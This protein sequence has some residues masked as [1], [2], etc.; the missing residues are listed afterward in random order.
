MA[1]V[2]G[3]PLGDGTPMVVS[4]NR[5]YD[6]DPYIR[7]LYKQDA[8][9]ESILPWEF[10]Q[11][12]TQADEQNFLRDWFGDR[13]I[14]VQGGEPEGYM[15]LKQVWMCS[16]LY[17]INNRVPAIV[18][19]WFTQKDNQELLEDAGMREHMCKIAE[20]SAFFP[21]DEPRGCGEKILRIVT[22]FI[23]Q[24]IQQSGPHDEPEKQGIAASETRSEVSTPEAAVHTNPTSAATLPP[25][26]PTKPAV[27]QPEEGQKVSPLADQTTLDVQK[28]TSNS[29]RR[30]ELQRTTSQPVVAGNH[31][32]KVVD[33]VQSPQPQPARRPR[34][35]SNGGRGSMRS[36]QR[37]TFD[38]NQHLQSPPGYAVYPSPNN[39]ASY[40]IYNQMPASSGAAMPFA[41]P[42]AQMPPFQSMSPE[43]FPMGLPQQYPAHGPQFPMHQQGPHQQGPH[44]QGPHQQGPHQQGPHQQGPHQQ[45]PHQQ[46]PHQQVMGSQPI[47]IANSQMQNPYY[48]GQFPLND[49][50]NEQYDNT[51]FG[52]ASPYHL[53]NETYNKRGGGHRKD[54]NG[55]RGGR[56]RGYP[57]SGG[58]GKSSRGKHDFASDGR[59]AFV[60]SGQQHVARQASTDYGTQF[61]MGFDR[62]DRR[63]SMTSNWRSKDEQA[64]PR[65][66]ESFPA[67]RNFS[68]PSDAYNRQMR[69]YAPPGFAQNTQ[70]PFR[71]M[72]V[73]MP[74]APH[75]GFSPIHDELSEL[76][77]LRPENV[78]TRFSVGLG[79]THVNKLLVFD[80]YKCVPESVLYDYFTRYSKTLR[81]RMQGSREPNAPLSGMYW[82]NFAN[83][84]EARNALEFSVHSLPGGDVRLEVP[85]QFWDPW[86]RSYPGFDVH[87]PASGPAKP[88]QLQKEGAGSIQGPNTPPRDSR[89]ADSTPTVE[90]SAVNVAQ[91][92]F[93]SGD[94]TP[95]PSTM[96][97]SKNDGGPAVIKRKAKSKSKD[98][99][100]PDQNVEPTQ[101]ANT[102]PEG[103][104]RKLREVD[105][106]EESA[107]LGA[108]SEDG[109]SA[110]AN[111]TPAK[112]DGPKK[113]LSF[114]T[115]GEVVASREDAQI[116]SEPAFTSEVFVK[117]ELPLIQHVEHKSSAMEVSQ[118]TAYPEQGSDKT[119]SSDAAP[120][121]ELKNRDTPDDAVSPGS[122]T[123]PSHQKPDEKEVDEGFNAATG[124][125]QIQKGSVSTPP[126]SKGS[127]VASKP[128]SASITAHRNEEHSEMQQHSAAQLAEFKAR[129]DSKVDEQLKVTPALPTSH[130]KKAAV[131]LQA[132]AVKIEEPDQK[133]SDNTHRQPS[134]TRRSVSGLSVPPTPAF[135]TAPSRPALVPDTSSVD[136]RA[137]SEQAEAP[138]TTEQPT[139]SPEAG[140]QPKHTDKSKGP[141][142][143]ES[144]NP[145]G[146]S[147]QKK[148]PKV[149]KKGTLRGKPKTGDFAE[150]DMS[151]A[152]SGTSTPQ[153]ALVTSVAA[154]GTADVVPEDIATE[155]QT[156]AAAP[157][158]DV[159]EKTRHA[160]TPE[161]DATE[162]TEKESKDRVSASTTQS[163]SPSKASSTISSFVRGIFGSNQPHASSPTEIVGNQIPSEAALTETKAK[164]EG[165]DISESV[166]SQASGQLGKSVA[167]A[168]PPVHH[169]QPP[170][171][172][173]PAS[174]DL[175]GLRDSGDSGGGDLAR[176]FDVGLGI[177]ASDE[178]AVTEETAKT[179]KKRPKKKKK[180]KTGGEG[181]DGATGDAADSKSTTAAAD[182]KVAEGSSSRFTSEYRA[183]NAP[184]ISDKISETSSHTLAGE[185]TSNP[186]TPSSSHDQSPS[187]RMIDALKQKKANDNLV[188]AKPLMRKTHRRVLT[189]KSSTEVVEESDDGEETN[190]DASGD[191]S[192]E[193]G[194]NK[195][196]PPVL[197]LYVGPGKVA[198]SQG[199]AGTFEQKMPELIDNAEK[200][201]EARRG[202]NVKP[203]AK[204]SK[205]EHIY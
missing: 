19:W 55:S 177:S 87:H 179:K 51:A 194:S 174:H 178:A 68:G 4:S 122:I 62:T 75:P 13:E 157:I 176:D 170:F 72:E 82:L 173:F 151:R 10:P 137:V 35:F 161:M 11:S 197:Y 73:Y 78:L 86:H 34:G 57:S 166:H 131:P 59:D 188:Q 39:P 77:K 16:A 1:V 118:T 144:L 119:A 164:G 30:N 140:S 199:F 80:E 156:H 109:G 115:Q 125:P 169:V 48:N 141:S 99:Q 155:S 71:I 133:P 36:N 98:K 182:P 190:D 143:T 127:R 22:D 117:T 191:E 158:V 104:E 45:G 70:M 17:N 53:S 149:A 121:A 136:D 200:E 93:L 29:S 165:S 42:S 198:D 47:Y 54:S 7:R 31:L 37:P 145:F 97:T 116:K 163:S 185:E 14:H 15:F 196:K 132:P 101:P 40:Q 65:Q 2:D 81:V 175:G 129:H 123:G 187:K 74:P 6:L 3:L 201:R 130:M 84:I 108:Q 183:V 154:A 63:A 100:L 8:R 195:K 124:S 126:V 67:G 186:P 52:N 83:N 142:Q 28:S 113:T 114:E 64:Q 26:T 205:G 189:P 152:V 18:D 111:G 134:D 167:A 85:K 24:R 147:T 32:P 107:M 43:N 38:R 76:A 66:H 204:T 90:N 146:K 171:Q 138:S 168:A 148:K 203:S 21:A 49:R 96:G 181:S 135:H 89:S 159:T 180:A 150:D 102:S 172:P 46:G 25:S 95:T 128:D 160:I 61:D 50:S 27:H 20:P 41:P 5:F 91:M 9:Y 192:G 88:L 56:S 110:E 106:I 193:R 12:G 60:P 23:K 103:H 162:D 184:T 105:V 58:R 69:P 139:P 94:T 44:Q 120:G 153:T 79:C 202:E 92:Q 112:D 33:A